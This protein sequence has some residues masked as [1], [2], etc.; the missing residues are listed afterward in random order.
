MGGGGGGSGERAGGCSI[1]FFCCFFFN[2][3][4]HFILPLS[5]VKLFQYLPHIS[6]KL[7]QEAE[8]GGVK[9][10]GVGGVEWEGDNLPSLL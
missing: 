2:K 1:Y 8:R 6:E 7:K 10:V 4:S 9:G 3:I 5:S